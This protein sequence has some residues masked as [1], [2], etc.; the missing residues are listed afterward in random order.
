M[1]FTAWHGVCH[2][3]MNP[4]CPLCIVGGTETNNEAAGYRGGLAYETQGISGYGG[5]SVGVSS[6]GG[7]ETAPGY[8]GNGGRP[9]SWR[10][11]GCAGR[12][13]EFGG[14]WKGAGDREC[15]GCRT[16]S[17]R[18]DRCGLGRRDVNERGAER[19]GGLEEG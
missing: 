13:A 2:Y 7:T 17:G 19:A 15:F 1:R 16:S 6:G 11:S 14:S 4:W 12:R 8:G 18:A 10:A 5:N 9:I 3:Q